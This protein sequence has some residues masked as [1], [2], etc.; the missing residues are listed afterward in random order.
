MHDERGVKNNIGMLTT[1]VSKQK[2][3]GLKLMPSETSLSSFFLLI[4]F[5]LLFVLSVDFIESSFVCFCF[6]IVLFAHPSIIKQRHHD[7]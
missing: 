5:S 4:V 2:L 3:I 6:L 1:A 7:I